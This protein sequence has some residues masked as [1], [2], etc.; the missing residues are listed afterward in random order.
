MLATISF[1]AALVVTEASATI[2]ASAVRG[3]YWAATTDSGGC[4][5]PIAKYSSTHSA[6]ALGDQTALGTLSFQHYYCGQIVSIN[7]GHGAV[8]AIVASTCNIGG[9]D[10]GVDMIAPTWNAATNSASPGLTTCSVALTTENPIALTTAAVCYYRPNSEFTN[11]YFKI[12]GV[13]NTGG[14]LVSGAT[15]RSSAGFVSSGN[16][17]QFAAGGIPFKS[18]NS[19]VFT[20]TDGTKSTFALSACVQPT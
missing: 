7:C 15:V 10:C 3:S 6:V 12:L 8:T 4:S 20:Y 13:L 1:L 5:L 19:V 2:S 17:Y 9:H 16:W 11:Q 14:R 18:T